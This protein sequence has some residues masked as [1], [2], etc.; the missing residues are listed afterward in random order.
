MNFNVDFHYHFDTDH[1]NYGLESINKSYQ[2]SVD[3]D[4]LWNRHP[5]LT[6][7]AII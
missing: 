6:L 1:F 4:E 3:Y 5:D 2:I 7:L